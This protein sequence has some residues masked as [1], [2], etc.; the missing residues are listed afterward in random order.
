MRCSI[1]CGR[2][3]SDRPGEALVDHDLHRAQHALVLAFGVDDAPRR[4]LRR[5]EQRLHD[6]ARVVDELAERLAVGVEARDRP[7]RHARVH[8][9]LAPPPARSRTMRRGSNG[10]GMRYSGPKLMV[11]DAVGERH[12]LGVLG[13]RELGD[14]AHRGELHLVVDGGGADVERAAEDEREAEDVVDLVRKVRAPGRDDAVGPRRL[15]HVGHDLGLGIGEREDERLVGHLLHHLRLEHPARRQAEEHVGAGDHLVQRARPGLLREALLVR[16]HLLA[17]ALVDHALDVG[18][19][20]VRARQAE[21]TSRS[22][23]ASAAAPAPEAHQLHLLDVLADDAQPVEDRG[24]D[25]DR[26]AVLVVVEHRDLHAL[27]Q[28][29]LDDEA[30]RRLDVLEVDAAEGRLERGD[31]VDQ[32][33][34]GRARRSRCRSSRCRRTS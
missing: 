13:L 28:R 19:A 11:L 34:A 16:V 27:A 4:L 29:A 14:R 12:L 22:R 7:R 26:G 8:R 30:L 31:D 24:A 32:L 33:V 5:G 21:R 15:G 2:P 6:E 9:R 17:P 23:Q 20:D 3:M 18:D 1:T 25:D 10:F